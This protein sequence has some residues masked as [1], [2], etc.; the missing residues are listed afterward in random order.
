M[1]LIWIELKLIG[2]ISNGPPKTVALE[3]V[4]LLEEA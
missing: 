1:N 4:K 3:V 2:L